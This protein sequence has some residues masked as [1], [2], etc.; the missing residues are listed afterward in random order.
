MLRPHGEPPRIR[1]LLFVEDIEC[2]CACAEDGDTEGDHETCKDCLREVKRLRVD[3]HCGD[4]RLLSCEV[5][6]CAEVV[7]NVDVIGC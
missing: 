7:G 4:S 5:G 1:G 2:V 6:R 3:L